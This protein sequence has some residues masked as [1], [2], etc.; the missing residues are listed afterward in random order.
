[1]KLVA[2][3][4][5][6]TRVTA[7]EAEVEQLKRQLAEV[8][9]PTKLWW[10]QIAG[11]FADDPANQVAMQLGRDYRVAQTLEENERQDDES[12]SRH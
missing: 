11:T 8:A 6:E 12:H 9:Q 3:L 2:I 4:E 1:M 10:E 5:I 7:L